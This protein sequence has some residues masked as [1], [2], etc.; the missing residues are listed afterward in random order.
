M[1]IASPAE[2][3][4]VRVSQTKIGWSAEDTNTLGRGGG[5]GGVQGH[6]PPGNFKI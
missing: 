3:G 4:Q 6:A 2:A 5:G 1:V